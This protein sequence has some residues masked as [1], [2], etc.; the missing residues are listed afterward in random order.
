MTGDKR[1]S[2]WELIQVGM[3]SDERKKKVSGSMTSCAS[4]CL[5][6]SLLSNIS[7]LASMM[8]PSH[9]YPL[10]PPSN[11][12]TWR[13]TPLQDDRLRPI[14]KSQTHTARR[15]G[16]SSRLSCRVHHRLSPLQ[17]LLSRRKLT[18]PLQ[19]PLMSSCKLS[20][21]RYRNRD[22][23]RR[24]CRL[25]QNQFTH[26]AMEQTR[27]FSFGNTAEKPI[28]ST[29]TSSASTST[30]LKPSAATT[31]SV[32]A[33]TS[34]PAGAP[35]LSSMDRIASIHP[36]TLPLF[37][38]VAL[39]HAPDL[40]KALRGVG[41]VIMNETDETLQKFSFLGELEEEKRD[42]DT[43]TT[44]GF[45][46][47]DSISK[48]LSTKA[49]P[50]GWKCDLCGL[51]SS[52]GSVKCDICEAPKP[53]QSKPTTSSG[54]PAPLLDS[55]AGVQP[56]LHQCLLL[57]RPL[58]LPVSLVGVQLQRRKPPGWKCGTCGLVSSP[59]SVKCD[60]CEAPKPTSLTN[61]GTTTSAL[62]FA[63]WGSGLNAAPSAPALAT[64]SSEQLG[65]AKRN[66]NVD[67]VD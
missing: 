34:T 19:L 25:R 33:D 11:P 65:E 62:S 1:M 10:R 20:R 44:N 35:I 39:A 63:G 36:A 58:R 31:P 13:S 4:S 37:T 21:A 38:F 7:D 51:V 3:G 55:L 5:Y 30:N 43:P 12:S 54:P 60:I 22:R 66:G 23:L 29:I 26:L 9:R 46:G 14:A 6:Y 67:C 52:V 59:S 28:A 27:L 40:S 2:D 42:V 50:A 17:P 53:G 45:K 18:H 32:T 48:S 15:R 41:S 57:H 64:T 49:P 24:L 8:H 61:N 16:L 47:H 56:L